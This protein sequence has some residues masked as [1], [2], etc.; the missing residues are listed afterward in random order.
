MS[1][2]RK[3][4]L[5]FTARTASLAKCASAARTALTSPVKSIS[6]LIVSLLMRLRYPTATVLRTGR[7]YSRATLSRTSLARAGLQRARGDDVAERV[8]GV[9]DFDVHPVAERAN[10][11]ASDALP[12]GGRRLVLVGLAGQDVEI[13]RHVQLGRRGPEALVVGARQLQPG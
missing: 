7:L 3:A 10:H 13:D 8:R 5:R 4:R 2:L 9:S 12:P 6:G 1:Q 11:V